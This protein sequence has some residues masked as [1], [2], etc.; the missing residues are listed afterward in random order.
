M[1]IINTNS[2]TQVNY[3]SRY[4]TDGLVDVSVKDEQTKIVDDFQVSATYDLG[5]INFDYDFQGVEGRYYY[6]IVQ[7]AD[8]EVVKFMMFCTDQEDLQDYSVQEGKYK[9]ADSSP[10]TYKVANG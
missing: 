3:T 9:T 7:Q 10:V 8:K 4:F 1:V 2:T 6:V 5:R